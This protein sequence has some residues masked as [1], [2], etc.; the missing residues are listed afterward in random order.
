[1][2]RKNSVREGNMAELQPNGSSVR[3]EASAG[4]E[5]AEQRMGLNQSD[6][7]RPF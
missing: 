7:S 6:I 5:T 3:P 2:K 1:M 4:G